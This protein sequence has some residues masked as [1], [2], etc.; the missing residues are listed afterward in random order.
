MKAPPFEYRYQ[1]GNPRVT[2]GYTVECCVDPGFRIRTQMRF[3]LLDINAPEKR[4]SDQIGSVT[5][6]I[7]RGVR[8]ATTSEPG[9]IAVPVGSRFPRAI[10]AA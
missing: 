2:D 10:R 8:C 3:W 5:T 1:A 9:Q 4:L 6:T 7:S